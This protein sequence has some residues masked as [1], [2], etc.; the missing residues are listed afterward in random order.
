MSESE[1]ISGA[2]SL[3]E[4][5]NCPSCEGAGEV[6]QPCADERCARYGY[7]YIPEAA[8][9]ARVGKDGLPDKLLGLAFGGYLVTGALGEGGIGK[10]YRGRQRSTG[11]SVAIKVLKSGG[12]A[13]MQTRF[14]GEARALA[15]LEHPNIVGLRDFGVFRNQTYI[16]MQF[17]EGTTFTEYLA[18]EPSLN[19]LRGLFDQ[20]LDALAYA[21]ERSIVHRD[22]KPD[23]VMLRVVGGRQVVKLLDFGL[24][25]DTIDSDATSILGG[26]PAFM[27][28]E[29]M[30]GIQIGPWTDL[31]AVGCMLYKAF[32]GERPYKGMSPFMRDRCKADAHDFNPAAEL[33]KS[34]P[35]PIA[36]FLQQALAHD[37]ETRIQDVATFRALMH[38]AFDAAPG[39]ASTVAGGPAIEDRTVVTPP[40][41]SLATPA[42]S[43]PTPSTPATEPANRRGLW[44]LLALGVVIIGVVV[45]LLTRPED[46]P[47]DA[48]KSAESLAQLEST[49]PSQAPETQ[50]PPSVAPETKAPPS[51]APPS[52]APPSTAPPSAAPETAAP[53]SAAPET[54]APSKPKRIK[55]RRPKPPA[56]KIAPKTAPS[57]AP[58]TAPPAA[59]KTQAPKLD[60][61][62]ATARALDAKLRD[63]RC[64][65]RAHRSAVER[66]RAT[67]R[68]RTGGAKEPSWLTRLRIKPIGPGATNCTMFE[69]VPG[70]SYGCRYGKRFKR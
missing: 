33:S 2:P 42:P 45:V 35:A 70:F 55:R 23:N 10:V 59:P 5:G 32:T 19:E 62:K 6:G 31:F 54:K 64:D 36:T 29:Q 30:R 57:V 44:S 52:V 37:P 41:V 68:D 14:V 40:P 16:V 43:T 13:A 27:A 61:L 38:A 1:S 26:T 24:A 39:A 47:K 63:C 48:P 34:Q 4:H 28:P 7:H 50:A 51:V 60:D 58:K 3:T 53:P 15:S 65:E 25:K 11:M 46:A 21:H 17:I 12:S 67:Y 20:L 9:E 69:S 49:P 18:T 66:L 8:F 22:I 56:V